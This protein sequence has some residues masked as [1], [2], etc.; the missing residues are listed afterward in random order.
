VTDPRAPVLVGAGAITQRAVDARAALDVFGLMAAATDQAG[1]DCGAP[2]AL[3]RIDL[4]LVPKG[5][6]SYR[7][8]GGVV[9]TGCG[10]PTARSVLADVGILQ[11]TLLTRAAQ[12]I[13]AG[14]ADVVLVTGAE[15]KQRDQLAARAGIELDDADRSTT[16]PDELL[17]PTGEILSGAEIERGLVLPVHQYALMESAIAHAAGRTPEEQ[18]ARVTELWARFA[19]VAAANP[20][21]WDRSGPDAAAL[22]TP[23][24]GN[25]M[26]ATPY[27]K[28]LSSQ[29]N[30]DQAAAVLLMA[31]ETAAALGV[32]PE[33]WVFA[34]SAA[35]SNHMV[36]L[37]RRA[38]L[39]R[40]PAFEAVAAALGLTGPGA[41]RPEVVELY[42]C[43]PAAVQVQADALGWPVG[44]PLTVTGGM[45]F[46]GGPL[47]NA[48]LQGLVALVRRLRAAPGETGLITS[49]SG[50][51]TKPG[52][53]LWSTRE[54][55]AGFRAVDVTAEAAART[56]EVPLLPGATGGAVVAGH[57]VVFEHG[58]PDRAVAIVDVEGGRTIA[59][60]RDRGIVAEM[61]TTDWVGR[62][63]EVTAP[64]VFGLPSVA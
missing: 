7:N 13:A 41:S 6:W 12:T 14:D 43:F 49:V 25:R 18:R 29:W 19:A 47:N 36:T 50:F 35:E 55:A 58:S 57:T 10:S 5:V 39:H 33:R 22:G 48:V 61:V 32:P 24:P 62:A 26:L 4:V 1:A 60:C 21:A 46:G 51:L 31:A 37:P 52:A 53:S 23:G 40:W 11:Q 34:H 64:G 20:D 28:Q 17:R 63:V 3:G 54:P 30:V 45:T 59:V 38:E 44:D 9:A 16:E 8:P 27:T 2:A 15:A 56:E 42:S